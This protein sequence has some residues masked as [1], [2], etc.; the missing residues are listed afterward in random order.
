MPGSKLIGFCSRPPPPSA[1]WWHCCLSPDEHS[2]DP[3][4]PHYGCSC[5]SSRLASRAVHIQ[6]CSIFLVWNLED[7]VVCEKC[8]LSDLRTAFAT[9][10]WTR[11]L[12]DDLL[13]CVLSC[14]AQHWWADTIY[15]AISKSR[16]DLSWTSRFCATLRF[17]RYE[18]SPNLRSPFCLPKIKD[19]R[20]PAISQRP[21]LHS[22][23]FLRC[24]SQEAGLG[25]NR[26]PNWPLV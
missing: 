13:D 8:L 6:V 22:V 18:N 9:L 12:G 14:S 15:H 5:V 7:P 25:V 20:T 3:H 10:L 17:C 24:D 16:Y 11:R 2:Q 4:G 23:A 26:S 1:V 21:P 19:A